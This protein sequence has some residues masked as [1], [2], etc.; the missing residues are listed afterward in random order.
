MQRTLTASLMVAILALTGCDQS[1][2]ADA[3]K[4][5]QQEP[6]HWAVIPVTTAGAAAIWRVNTKTGTLEYCW[7]VDVV[8]CDPPFPAAKQLSSE[9][10]EALNWAEAHPDD[11]RAAKIKQRLGV[12]PGGLRIDPSVE[13][14]LK[15]Y[16]VK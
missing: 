12:Q 9:D 15:K 1:N 10:A 5:A 4:V 7:R 14:I 13:A 16:G 2:N 3:A 6:D 8:R 11:P